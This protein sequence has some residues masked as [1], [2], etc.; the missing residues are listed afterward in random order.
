MCF[1]LT[2]EL[3][4]FATEVYLASCITNGNT[5]HGTQR[6]GNMEFPSH[7]LIIRLPSLNQIHP[8]RFPFCSIGG[9]QNIFSTFTHKEIKKCSPSIKNLSVTLHA[10]G[11]NG[12]HIKLLFNTAEVIIDEKNVKDSNSSAFFSLNKTFLRRNQ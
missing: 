7:I 1:M 2:A 6:P 4:R 12:K 10:T 9:F 8:Y 11:T 3:R 5:P